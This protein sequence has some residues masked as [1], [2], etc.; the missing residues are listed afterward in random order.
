VPTAT[1]QT[2][3]TNTANLGLDHK[4]RL[5]VISGSQEI[6]RNAQCS[7]S[8]QSPEPMSFYDWR[9]GISHQ[10]ITALQAHRYLS[11]FLRK[12][13]TCKCIVSMSQAYATG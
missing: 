5:Q 10:R 8:N 11:C 1:A 9:Y 2:R 4:T 13:L 7:R 12:N 6:A 3:I